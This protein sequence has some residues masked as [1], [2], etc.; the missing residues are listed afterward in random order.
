MTPITP[1]YVGERLGNSIAR[2]GVGRQQDPRIKKLD[3]VSVALIACPSFKSKYRELRISPECTAA[4]AD[5]SVPKTPDHAR[6]L[7]GRWANRP[8]A[9]L[10]GQVSD[11][12]FS[13]ASQMA[14][15]STASQAIGAH[16]S[17]PHR[18]S[19]IWEG[20]RR[21]ASGGG[22]RRGR[23]FGDTSE[24]DVTW[25]RKGGGWWLGATRLRGFG[26]L[27]LAPM[28]GQRHGVNA[29]DGLFFWSHPRNEKHLLTI[30]RGRSQ[31]F[32]DSSGCLFKRWK[33]KQLGRSAAIW[34][35]RSSRAIKQYEVRLWS[36][37]SLR[38]IAVRKA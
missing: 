34:A 16:G 28:A 27:G 5:S 30:D 24:S 13:L 1:S 29:I 22:D 19:V 23:D 4:A 8:L 31:V 12:G 17:P 14:P 11:S 35:W 33:K 26:F 21:L 37:Y 38:W 36:L 9:K 6:C 7:D 25:G 10:S 2:G 3:P 18:R 20:W 32:T 15:L